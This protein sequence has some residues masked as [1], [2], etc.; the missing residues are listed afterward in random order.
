MCLPFQDVSCVSLQ[1][2][3]SPAEIGTL[4]SSQLSDNSFAAISFPAAPVSPHASPR[5]F[6]HA[7][8]CSLQA[9][10]VS[11]SSASP[12]LLSC[13]GRRDRCENRSFCWCSLNALPMTLMAR[14][15]ARWQLFVRLLI[16]SFSPLA[17]SSSLSRRRCWTFERTQTTTTAHA[18]TNSSTQQDSRSHGSPG[19]VAR[20]L[21]RSVREQETG[22]C[23]LHILERKRTRSDCSSHGMR[24]HY[25]RGCV[26]SGSQVSCSSVRCIPVGMCR[27]NRWLLPDKSRHFGRGT[28]STRPRHDHS[29]YPWILRDTGTGM[30]SPDQHSVHLWT[31]KGKR[32][33]FWPL[34]ITKIPGV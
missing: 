15:L 20:N 11:Y 26:G 16:V 31:E 29:S 24:R 2:Q 4:H 9:H 3:K 32:M 19:N 1:I 10:V 18:T 30:S 6:L 25:G 13:W 8:G 17:T 34:L 27:C 21:G 22:S 7:P 12:S 28:A 5:I 14:S 33:R 23:V